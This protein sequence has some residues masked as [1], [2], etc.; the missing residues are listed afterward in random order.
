MEV[1]HSPP[2]FSGKVNRGWA[3]EKLARLLCS[4]HHGRL[5]GI[6]DDTSSKGGG[7]TP[8]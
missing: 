7:V 5:C 6:V 3:D 8:V 2:E 4:C 1:L